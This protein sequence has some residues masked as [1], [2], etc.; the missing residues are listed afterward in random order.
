MKSL[1]REKADALIGETDRG[2]DLPP[3]LDST[4]ITSLFGEIGRRFAVNGSVIEAAKIRIVKTGQRL[5]IYQ[6]E[7]PLLLHRK[8]YQK[9][10]D[11]KRPERGQEYRSRKAHRA[12]NTLRR[13]A[14]GNFIERVVF[15]TLTFNNDQTFD[16]SDISASNKRLRAFIKRLQLRF[17]ELK[18]IAVLEFQQRGAVHYH[19]LCNLPYIE[20]EELSSIWSHGFVDIQY[21]QDTQ[22]IGGYLAKYMAKNSTDPRFSE[23]RSYFTSKNLERPQTFY[24]FQALIMLDKSLQEKM[25][26]A[27]QN[28]YYSRFNGKVNFGEYNLNYISPFDGKKKDK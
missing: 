23:H 3:R 27:F 19:L 12:N 5:E 2:S 26:L 21:V 9:G 10:L 20:K 1:S 25:S 18:Y 13:L 16:I 17:P 28:E 7:K 14:N 4:V 6:Y 15:V 22:K 11:R 8:T 24:G